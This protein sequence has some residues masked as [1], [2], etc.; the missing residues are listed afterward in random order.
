MAD[1]SPETA[2]AELKLARTQRAG[3]PTFSS[4]YSELDFSW[5][6]SVANLEKSERL[7][8]GEKII[9]LKLRFTSKAKQEQMN[10]RAPIFGFL[11]DAM[12]VGES[13]DVGNYIHPKI[14]PEL[15]FKTS[16]PINSALTVDEAKGYISQFAVGGEVIDSRYSE[17][18][19]SLVDA[20]A[21]NTS[22]A[23]ICTG[24]WKSIAEFNPSN[25]STIFS[26]NGELLFQSDLTA[27]LGDPWQA[28]VELSRYLQQMGEELPAGSIIFS[29]AITE[30]VALKAG[31]NY[32]L[33]IAGLG[34]IEVNAQ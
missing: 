10:L 30:A 23:G 15:V 25:Q 3:V 11:T 29:G 1:I 7:A 19:F 26:A 32:R 16:R 14:E 18:S 4:R 12:L 6:H 27:I 28:I 2:H 33:E 21:D 22:A 31:A 24:A 9:C 13:I 5:S 8:A 20:I 17:Y 34:Q